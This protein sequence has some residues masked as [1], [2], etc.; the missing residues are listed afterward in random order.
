MYYITVLVFVCLYVCTTL[1]QG[2]SI[3]LV[4]LVKVL[5]LVFPHEELGVI[6]P[7]ACELIQHTHI[8]LLSHAGD[9]LIIMKP[10][11]ILIALQSI[12]LS[13]IINYSIL[14]IVLPRILTLFLHLL[15]YVCHKRDEMGCRQ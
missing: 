10:I 12:Y 1:S 5:I 8:G 7:D 9:I 13:V 14:V 4:I 3:V 2:N 6:F 11:K 15:Y